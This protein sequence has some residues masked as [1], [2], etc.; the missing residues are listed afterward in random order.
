MAFF[1]TRAGVARGRFG[2]SLILALV[3]SVVCTAGAAKSTHPKPDVL[4]QVSEIAEQI[5]E[6]A[7]TIDASA[8]R[9][10]I[11]DITAL[12]ARLTSVFSR[13][14]RRSLDGLVAD[15]R[16]AWTLSSFV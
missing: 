14:R 5:S 4:S 10:S 12:D 9:K 15:M 11:S 16:T 3:I 2:V 1:G 7:P 6:N 8:F 13:D